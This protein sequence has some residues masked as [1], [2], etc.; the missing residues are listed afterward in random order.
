M[1]TGFLQ[2]GQ[3]THNDMCGAPPQCHA[4]CQA[5]YLFHHIEYPS[6]ILPARVSF[7]AQFT[8]EETEVQRKKEGC[9]NSPCSLALKLRFEPM[10]AALRVSGT[11]TL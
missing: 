11:C 8:Q 10:S 7:V 3:N 6:N 9:P 4:L 2:H 5:P 1:W